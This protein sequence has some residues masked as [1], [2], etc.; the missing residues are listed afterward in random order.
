MRYRILLTFSMVVLFSELLSAEVVEKSFQVIVTDK[1]TS[2]PLPYAT[3]CW[4]SVAA[5]Q[6]GNSIANA[7]GVATIKSAGGRVAMVVSCVG[8]KPFRDTV[9]LGSRMEISLTEDIFNL[10]QVT[11]TGTRTPR[12]LKETPV[13]TQLVT[14]KDIRITSALT[15]KDVLEFEIPSIE[16]GQHGGSATL[17]TQGLDGKYTLVLIDGERMAGETDGNVDF[18]RIS[19]AN[20]EQV[21]IVRGAS[22]ALYGSNALG[23]VINIITKKPGKKFDVAVDMRYAEP[24][25]RNNTAAA[26]AAYEDS[27]VRTFYRNQDRQN[28]NGNI[29]LGFKTDHMYSNTFFGYKSEDGY[30]LFDTKGQKRYYPQQDSSVQTGVKPE[31]TEI[32]GFQDYSISNKTGYAGSNWSAEVRGSYYNHE[33]FDFSRDRNHDRYRDYTLGGFGERKVGTQSTLRFSFNH[34]V[35]GKYTRYETIDSDTLN[36]EN[37]FDNAKLIFNGRY[38]TQHAILASFEFQHEYLKSVMFVDKQLVLHDISD[39]VVVLQDEFSVREGLDIVASL[40]S[41]YNSAYREHFT[42]SITVHS[43][44]GFW[45]YRLTYGQGFR[46]PM[47]KELYSNWPHLTL[48]TIIGSKDLKPETSNFYSFSTDYVNTDRKLNATVVAS[49]SHISNKIDGY[50]SSNQKEYYL[51]NIDE[52]RVFST[53]FLARWKPVNSLQLKA[54]YVYTK[55]F[56]SSERV[57]KAAICPHSVTAQMEYSLKQGKYEMVAN[58]S[59]RIMGTKDASELDPLNNQFYDTSYPAYSLWNLTLNHRFGEHFGIT[60]GVKNLFNYKAPIV[61][62]STST[63]V[64]RRFYVSVA[65]NF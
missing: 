2:A 6:S 51:A 39:A 13:L 57:K 38:K 42:P 18:S 34:D 28:L 49:Y 52:W 14:R 40:R 44:H 25:Q 31:P 56:E 17:K 54:G 11:V 10:E 60:A 26:V 21:E 62:F 41:G 7:D 27:Y 65:Y 32:S 45:N 33:E 5:K 16:M 3:I 37:G 53:E 29:S 63:T 8:Y 46:S 55:V 61:T 24:N 43:V 4:Q 20:I 23:S 50:W 30:Q 12:S 22:S 19:A 36:Y 15:L 35:Y 9:E 1:G 64:G 58:L 59:G 48:F 47:L